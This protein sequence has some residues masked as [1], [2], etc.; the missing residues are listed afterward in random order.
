MSTVVEEKTEPETLLIVLLLYECRVLT[1]VL[2]VKG[3]AVLSAEVSI[4]PGGTELIEE[5][6]FGVEIQQEVGADADVTKG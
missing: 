3:M 1:D 2:L 6:V 5:M 4:A